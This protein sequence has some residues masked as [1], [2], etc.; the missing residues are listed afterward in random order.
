MTTGREVLLTQLRDQLTP[1]NRL[2]FGRCHRC[3]PLQ[4]HPRPVGEVLIKEVSQLFGQNQSLKAVSIIE[5]GS[6]EVCKNRVVRLCVTFQIDEER[7]AQIFSF[8]GLARIMSGQRSIQDLVQERTWKGVTDVRCNAALASKFTREIALHSCA[9]N[10][11]GLRLEEPQSRC[12]SL[13]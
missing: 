2:H 6:L 9:L 1:Q 3:L 10:E 5:E 4:H 13:A 11:D 12:L 7:P 8:K